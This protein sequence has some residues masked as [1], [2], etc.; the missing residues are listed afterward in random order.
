MRA[1][2]CCLVLLLAS[3]A[4][5]LTPAES[6][7]TCQ[8]LAVNGVEEWPDFKGEDLTLAAHMFHHE[9]EE[10]VCLFIDES[11]KSK[12]KPMY[13]FLVYKKLNF[14]LRLAPKDMTLVELKPPLALP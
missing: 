4:Y 1:F 14:V 10:L 13:L 8:A 9:D 11:D 3:S 5:A 6:W 7:K 2:I 12:S